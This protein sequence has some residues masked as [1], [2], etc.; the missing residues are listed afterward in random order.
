MTL[1]LRC[2]VLAVGGNYFDNRSDERS[3]PNIL[4][5][6]ESLIKSAQETSVSVAV[7]SVCPRNTPGAVIKRINALNTGLKVLCDDLEM[8]FIDNDP[9]F[10]LQDGSINDGY[11][12]P[13][14]VHLTKAATNKLVMNLKLELHHGE[15]SAHANH[16]RQ[17]PTQ[18]NQH[19][20]ASE[21][22][23]NPSHD[24][25]SSHEHPSRRRAF[26]KPA[27][28]NPKRQ[29]ND[30]RFQAPAPH[31]PQIPFPSKAGH[32]TLA[33]FP[34]GTGHPMHNRPSNQWRAPSFEH[35]PTTNR[36]NALE[37][38]DT[39]PLNNPN[40]PKPLLTIET[41]PP[42]QPLQTRDTTATTLRQ[43]TQQQCQ[44]CLGFDHTAVTC[45]SKEET[46][47]NCHQVGH[48]SRAC[49]AV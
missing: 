44:L 46:C 25:Q 11:M 1:N 2:L 29:D 13:D 27:F 5:K 12:L 17:Q 34:S 48:L 14:G 21:L 40:R 42:L 36:G 49:S 7:S 24:T 33:P 31:Q 16:R 18:I 3:I 45:R 47:Y 4:S 9:T 35:R 39:Q 10:Y 6:C 41:R 22:Q 28:H 15:A 26:S 38:R 32:S 19:N 43:N 8:E 30:R 20:A 23:M 37:R